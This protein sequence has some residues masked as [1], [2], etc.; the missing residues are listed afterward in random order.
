MVFVFMGQL[1]MSVLEYKMYAEKD[2]RVREAFL[3]L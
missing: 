3:V 2:A 1:E